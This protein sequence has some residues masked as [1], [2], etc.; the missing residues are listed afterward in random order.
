M[1]WKNEI[2]NFLIFLCLF[3]CLFLSF[4]HILCVLVHL[5]LSDSDVVKRHDLLMVKLWEFYA[6]SC[7]IS[8]HV[9]RRKLL[10]LSLIKTFLNDTFIPHACG[11][12][13]SQTNGLLMEQVFIYGLKDGHLLLCQSLLGSV[14]D[15]SDLDRVV[16]Y[17]L[18]QCCIPS[19]ITCKI[20]LTNS[21]NRVCAQL[22]LGINQKFVIICMD[23]HLKL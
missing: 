5:V 9:S 20:S 11:R 6:E 18:Y 7:L 17:L 1:L 15:P 4:L 21:V 19:L 8:T 16:G 3:Q 22:L 14:P 13:H 2:A 12:V 23:L 10:S